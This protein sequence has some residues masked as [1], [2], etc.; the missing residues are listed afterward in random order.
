MSIDKKIESSIITMPEFPKKI[1]QF[2]EESG[3]WKK[4]LEFMLRE[5]AQLK[6]RL[7]AL[8]RNNRD[9][10]KDFLELA[11]QFQSSFIREDESINLLRRDISSQEKWLERDIYEDGIIKGVVFRQQKLR[12]DVRRA[13]KEFNKL[14]KQFDQYEEAARTNRA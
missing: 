8:V 9:A 4:I 11:E 10:D 6:N 2:Q 12:K 1:K 14:K 7:A 13:N 5:N 3:G